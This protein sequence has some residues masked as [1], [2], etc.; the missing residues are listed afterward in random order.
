MNRTFT[1]I[2]QRTNRILGAIKSSRAPASRETLAELAE[3]DMKLEDQP[4]KRV[5]VARLTVTRANNRKTIVEIYQDSTFNSFYHYFVQEGNRRSTKRHLRTAWRNEGISWMG[6]DHLHPAGLET[7]AKRLA[8]YA[9]QSNPVVKTTL[10]ILQR[11]A[12]RRLLKVSPD[13]LGLTKTTRLPIY[14]PIVRSS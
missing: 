6:F 13:Q 11:K 9:S 1:Q 5:V 10:R 7:I 2:N 12:Y 3:L 4:V 14:S 8:F